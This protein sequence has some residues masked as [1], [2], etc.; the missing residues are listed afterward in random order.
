MSTQR[1]GT[2]TADVS[3]VCPTPDDIGWPTEP[4]EP[5]ERLIAL[6]PARA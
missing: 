4:A 6:L 1:I 3:N 5:I 2:V